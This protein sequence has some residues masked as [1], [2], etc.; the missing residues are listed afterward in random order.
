MDCVNN[1]AEPLETIKIKERAITLSFSVMM[2]ILIISK[3]QI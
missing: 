3:I 1:I 2:G